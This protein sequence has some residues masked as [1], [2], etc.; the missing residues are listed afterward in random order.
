MLLDAGASGRPVGVMRLQTAGGAA[1]TK[2][3]ANGTKPQAATLLRDDD[4]SNGAHMDDPH[5]QA[6]L[7][8]G[9]PARY[10]IAALQ[11]SRGD[12]A[13]A[14]EL[15][16]TTLRSAAAT[17]LGVSVPDATTL[18]VSPQAPG[19]AVDTDACL[20]QHDSLTPVANPIWSEEHDVL[21]AIYGDDISYPT[22]SHL[23]LSL[24]CSQVRAGGDQAPVWLVL[25]STM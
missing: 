6:L 19:V 1:S 21:G 2:T 22:A 14:H 15:L 13:G 17:A 9:Y 16:F 7:K 23:V 24:E 8:Y 18:D 25:C 4:G 3:T 5:V 20:T 11:E 10:V 12:L